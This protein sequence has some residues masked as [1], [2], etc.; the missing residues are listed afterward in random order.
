[1]TRRAVDVV[2][3]PEE[4]I[5]DLAIK[6]NAKLVESFGPEIVLNKE[7]CLPHISLAMGCVDEENIAA[8]GEILRSIAKENPLKNLSVLGIQTAGFGRKAVSAFKI[9]RTKELQSL[10][11]T[12]TERLAPYFSYDVNADMIADEEVEQR[13]LQWINR[14]REKSSYENFSPH[15]TIG[16]GEMENPA[17]SMDFTALKLAL[18]HLGNHCTCRKILVSVEL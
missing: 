13:T 11:E 9:E 8:V 15:I 18:C 6:A 4:A 7:D 1:M 16:Y 5:A 3:L 10:H 2:L 12:V 17:F 14:F